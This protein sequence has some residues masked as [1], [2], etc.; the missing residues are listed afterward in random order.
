MTPDDD[1]TLRTIRR[2]FGTFERFCIGA[3][4]IIGTLSVG[5]SVQGARKDAEHGQR[6]LERQREL[7][8]GLDE[9]HVSFV[10]RVASATREL[11]SSE[12]PDVASPAALT[13]L[14]GGG[15]YL[16]VISSR[17]ADEREIL[18]ASRESSKDA[19]ASCLSLGVRETAAE[20]SACAPE[21]GCVGEATARLVNLRILLAGFAPFREGWQ[22]SA[23]NATGIE[24]AVLSSELDVAA[25][26]ALSRARSAVDDAS[27]VLLAVDEVPQGTR[28]DKGETGL[29]TV[30]TVPHDVKIAVLDGRTFAPL[31]RAKLRADAVPAASPGATTSVLR[32]VQGCSLGLAVAERVRGG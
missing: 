11:A 25:S 16:R 26:G 13:A 8:V 15:V 18:R 31:F 23:A 28:M 30:Q 2:R 9:R 32:Q 3:A 14:Q 6:L 24:L 19:F 21:S 20:P 10:E 12:A 5:A 17:A 4:V 27:F 7:G 29:A 22:A 1:D